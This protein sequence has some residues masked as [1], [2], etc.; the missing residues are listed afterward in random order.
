MTEI[1]QMTVIK[2]A[3]G[4]RDTDTILADGY[5]GTPHH[6]MKSHA[7]Y[8]PIIIPKANVKKIRISYNSYIDF[9]KKMGNH[10]ITKGDPA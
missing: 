5:F 3:V 8:A 10:Q 7:I 1:K 4:M 9:V 6:F 2:L